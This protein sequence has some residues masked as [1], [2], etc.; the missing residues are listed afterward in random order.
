MLNY[1]THIIIIYKAEILAT[2]HLCILI[3]SNIFPSSFS[4]LL[5]LC[6]MKIFLEK[7]I[8]W[9]QQHDNTCFVPGQH[10]D[11][12]HAYMPFS[13][14]ICFFIWI[15]IPFI[16]PSPPFFF[17]AVGTVHNSTKHHVAHTCFMKKKYKVMRRL[18]T[19][20]TPTSFTQK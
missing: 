19:F 5:S 13:L 7:A 20:M 1:R 9:P 12:I 18:R 15:F 17:R 6:K 11:L 4:F 16:S 2:T 10:A 8:A 3:Q 14:H